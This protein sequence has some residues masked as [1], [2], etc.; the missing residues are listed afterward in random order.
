MIKAVI[1][2]Y[3][4]VIMPGGGANEPAESLSA[5]LDIPL[6]K[7]KHIIALLWDDYIT[8]KLNETQYWQQ[9]EKEYGK[10]I[11]RD[12]RT[13]RSKWID[14]APLPEMVQL[15]QDL[16]AKGYI[17]GLLSNITISTEAIIRTGGGYALFEPCV[18]SC[19]VGFAKPSL[20]IYQELL[21]QLPGI[22]PKEIV[23]IDDQQ[24]YLDTAHS[25]GLATILAKNSTQIAQDLDKLLTAN[26]T[27]E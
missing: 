17:V 8:G 26:D 10:P 25:L 2:D 14:V 24:R 4:G 13:A 16:K 11:T 1:F 5:F 3:G 15:I 19:Q 22:Q 21:Q 6:G 7:A 20:A 12:T 27:N 9:V 23:F 18:L